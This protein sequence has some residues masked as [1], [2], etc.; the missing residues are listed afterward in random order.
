MTRKIAMNT[1]RQVVQ[2]LAQGQSYGKIQGEMKVSK[3]WISKINGTIEANELTHEKFLQLTDQEIHQKLYPPTSKARDEPNWEEVNEQLKMKH[4]TRLLAYEHYR[5]NCPGHKPYSYSSFC[6]MFDDWKQEHLPLE[7]FTNLDA[8][9]GDCLEIDFAGDPLIWV[10]KDAV[11]HKERLFVATLP[12]S[13]MIFAQVFPDETQLSWI[14][15]TLE[16]L[17]YFGGVPNN[18]IMDNAK[19]LVTRADGICGDI[20]PAVLDFCEHYGIR[21][22]T[23]APA[24]PKQ[25]NRVEASVCMVERW[26]IG[27]LKLKQK[28]PILAGNKEYLKGMVRKCLDSLNE[29]PWQGRGESRKSCF[30]NEEKHLLKPLPP[31]SYSSGTWKVLK[32]DRGH[33]IRLS[34]D[35]GHRY[36]VPAE[37]VGKKMHVKITKNHV[38]IFDYESGVFLATHNRCYGNDVD[39]THILREHLTPAEAK[40]RLTPEQ[41]IAYFHQKGNLDKEI[42]RTFVLN[43][44]KSAFNGRRLCGEVRKQVKVYPKET[45]EKAMSAC[46]ELDIYT[47]RFFRSQCESIFASELVESVAA[48]K[49][50]GQEV[51]YVTA[52]HENIRNDYE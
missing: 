9:P 37:Y 46:N 23:C 40:T 44:F 39:K 30:M 15:G 21:G 5:E 35:G 41:W 33:C 28:G 38:K 43:S 25:K 18:L 26:I 42:C 47:T 27:K 12:Y 16:A 29:R 49:T 11:I 7:T 20:Q 17:E 8:V 13:G 19:A 34:E 1:I 2:R 32:V 48:N 4:M 10:D 14:Q 24:S 6:R 3:G 45:V 36:S 51:D 31:Y 52:T 50:S 22:N